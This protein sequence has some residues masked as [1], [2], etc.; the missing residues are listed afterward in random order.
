MIGRSR[1]DG[2]YFIAI[3]SVPDCNL[4]FEHTE[5]TG[6]MDRLAPQYP[7]RPGTGCTDRPGTGCTDLASTF[8][9]DILWTSNN[10]KH[11]YTKA[12]FDGCTCVQTELQQVHICGFRFDWVDCKGHRGLCMIEFVKVVF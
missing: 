2:A 11:K 5:E 8:S 9:T 10:H 1:I 12:T 7:D 4:S 6:W 3:G